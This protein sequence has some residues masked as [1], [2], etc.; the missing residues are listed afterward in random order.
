MDHLSLTLKIA[1]RNNS[2]PLLPTSASDTT[3]TLTPW[4]DHT[5]A[6][7]RACPYCS[8]HFHS[9][10]RGYILWGR[11][12]RTPPSPGY[13]SLSAAEGR[14]A[15]GLRCRRGGSFLPLEVRPRGVSPT[16]E[17]L[18]SFRYPRSRGKG[19]SSNLVERRL[20]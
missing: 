12:V 11:K 14:R 7:C 16:R 2:T 20:P 17:R 10:D 5:W 18:R 15:K 19:R 4:S 13:P 1:A 9:T 8:L 6:S 3:R